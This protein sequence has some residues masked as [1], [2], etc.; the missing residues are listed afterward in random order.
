MG[1]FLWENQAKS[2]KNHPMKSEEQRRSVS[3]SIIFSKNILVLWL[4][5]ISHT[6]LLY[7]KLG[8]KLGQ[9]VEISKMDALKKGHTNNWVIWIGWW[10]TVALLDLKGKMKWAHL[11]RVK[12]KQGVHVPIKS[13]D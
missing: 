12:Q 1:N 11:P 4:N 6:S 8:L 2:L 10:A 7:N 3:W 9:P 13:E 5:E